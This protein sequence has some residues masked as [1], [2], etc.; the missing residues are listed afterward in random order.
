MG[1][2][3]LPLDAHSGCVLPR[4]QR[5]C[6]STTGFAVDPAAVDSVVHCNCSASCPYRCRYSPAGPRECTPGGRIVPAAPGR[7]T[8]RG[9][10]A[11]NCLPE[12]HAI[13]DVAMNEWVHSCIVGQLHFDTSSRGCPEY[14]NSADKRRSPHPEEMDVHISVQLDGIRFDFA[15]CVTAALLFV[16]DCRSGRH[17]NQVEVLP[18]DCLAFPRLPNE[19]LYL[20]P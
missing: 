16:Q 19:R 5:P 10:G 18:G 17:P 7:S 15:A 11:S 8:V 14:G 9:A 6:G 2:L 1:V 3:T 20:E 12:S 13:R 4:Y